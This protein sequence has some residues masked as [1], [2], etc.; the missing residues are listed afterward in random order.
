MA[1]I[2]KAV[3]EE[4]IEALL[5]CADTERFVVTGDLVEGDAN[6]LANHAFRVVYD[7]LV[8]PCIVNHGEQVLWSEA[9]AL[10]ADGWCPGDP[11]E[12]RS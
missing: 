6:R 5:C 1:R 9:A 12:V 10:L 11:V 7:A 4:A 3:R 2:S 8:V